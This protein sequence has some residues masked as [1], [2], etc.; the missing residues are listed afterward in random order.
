MLF[1][2]VPFFSFLLPTNNDNVEKL[3]EVIQN[4]PLLPELPFV[5]VYSER[6]WLPIQQCLLGLVA[7]FLPGEKKMSTSELGKESSG[8]ISIKYPNL[9]WK[10]NNNSIIK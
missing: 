7:K 6:T 5:P 4:H 9:Y 8:K 10:R 2:C 1:C 3:I